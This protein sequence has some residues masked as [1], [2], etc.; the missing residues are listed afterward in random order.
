MTPLGWCGPSAKLRGY[1]VRAGDAVGLVCSPKAGLSAREKLAAQCALL[2]KGFAFVPLS[3]SSQAS[4]EAC[5]A[6][7]EDRHEE[8]A[9]LF[10]RI[11]G[12]AQFTLSFER[13]RAA[14]PEG[15]WL[16]QR[17]ENYQ[18]AEAALARARAMA[19]DLADMLG[20]VDWRLQSQRPGPVLD[21]LLSADAGVQG[22]ALAR[23]RQLGEQK[24]K[25]WA[26]TLIGP[27]PAYAFAPEEAPT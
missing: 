8:L 19:D 25:G 4:V 3:P 15:T 12:R 21:V 10:E 27:L 22:A 13:P 26:A 7:G 23:L 2:G 16:R 14:S 24:F 5:L 18:R 9:G 6:W 17:A 1:H 20:A 11:Q